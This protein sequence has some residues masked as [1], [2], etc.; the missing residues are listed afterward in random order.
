MLGS[1]VFGH[2]QMQAAINAISELAAEI[3]A[4]TWEWQA[5]ANDEALAKA[6]ADMSA[7]AFG[8]AYQI[9]DKQQRYARLDSIRSETI[10]KLT[11]DE[12]GVSVDHIRAAM[13]KLEKTIVRSRIIEGG[14]RGGRGAFRGKSHV[15]SNADG[16]GKQ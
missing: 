16:K 9:A 7:E 1:V 13:D 10:D 3:N 11:N 12:S 5:A 8:E 6:V 15:G 14:T 2:E 4:P